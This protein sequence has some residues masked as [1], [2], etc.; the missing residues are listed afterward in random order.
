MIEP[1][2]VDVQQAV[3]DD[4]GDRLAATRWTE[5]CPSTLVTT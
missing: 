1:F 4:L 2:V 3:L 5:D